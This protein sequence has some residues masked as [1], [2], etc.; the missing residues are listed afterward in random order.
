MISEYS[1]QNKKHNTTIESERQYYRKTAIGTLATVVAICGLN[2]IIGDLTHH[3]EQFPK[4]PIP[5]EEKVLSYKELGSN[6]TIEYTVRYGDTLSEIAD[7]LQHDNVNLQDNSNSQIVDS[8]IKANNLDGFIVDTKIK[9]P[10]DDGINDRQS[11]VNNHALPPDIRLR[12]N[13]K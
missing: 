2:N 3:D 10:D 4:E 13:N 5:A 6:H 1:H 8:I 7:D 11:Y 9:L 12:N